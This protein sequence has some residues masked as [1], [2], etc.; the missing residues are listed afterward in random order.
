M[1]V[2]VMMVFTKTVGTTLVS[3][4]VR[5]EPRTGFSKKPHRC[6]SYTKNTLA[7]KAS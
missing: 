5:L 4:F 2:Y 3:E 6:N 7:M 1:Q